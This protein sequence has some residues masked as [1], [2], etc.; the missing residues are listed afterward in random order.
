[1]R[2]FLDSLLKA[3]G[4]QVTGFHNGNFFI[5]N[6]YGCVRLRNSFDMQVTVVSHDNVYTINGSTLY[7]GGNGTYE[8][9]IIQ[10]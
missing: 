2:L 9:L 4:K 10:I 7:N 8:N 3:R 5:G 1:M 6:I